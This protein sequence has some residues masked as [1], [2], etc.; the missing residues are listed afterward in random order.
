M[1]CENVLEIWKKENNKAVYMVI[2]VACGW[3]G[4]VMCLCKP[5]NSKIC[6]QKLNDMDRPTDGHSVLQSREHATKK[7][8][9][10]RWK[11]VFY[12]CQV[13]M[14]I[15]QNSPAVMLK[16]TIGNIGRWR[17]K[18]E[19]RRYKDASGGMNNTIK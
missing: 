17:N 3:A 18:Q 10:M 4:A 14:F 12:R 1:V 13:E 15:S 9:Q 8:F 19:L 7:F 11:F 16:E 2:S 5:R 6:D